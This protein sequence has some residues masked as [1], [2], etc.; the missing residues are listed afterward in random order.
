MSNAEDEKQLPMF[1]AGEMQTEDVYSDDINAESEDEVSVEEVAELT[2]YSR[3][4]TVGTIMQQIE[5]GNIDLNPKFQRRNAWNDT[6]RS[7]LIESLLLNI[8]VPEIVLA[9]DLDKK[10]S[11]IVIDGK[12]RLLAIAGY[13][14]PGKFD[15]WNRAK[16]SRLTTRKDLNG[17][18]YEELRRNAESERLL[19]NSDIRCTV[20][21]NYKSPSVLYDIFYRLNTGSTPLS[22]QELRQALHRGGFSNYLIEET[23]KSIPLHDAM[24]LSGPDR[25]LV[26]AE[27]VLRYVAISLFGGEYRGNLLQFLDASMERLNQE[28]GAREGDVRHIVAEFHETLA[29]MLS[30]LG[31]GKIGRKFTSGRWEP[32]FNRVLLEV[33]VFYLSMLRPQVASMVPEDFLSAFEAFCESDQD[34][35]DSVETTT[36]TNEKYERRY[37][38]YQSFVNGFFGVD[39]NEIPVRVAE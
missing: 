3:D 13:E 14:N 30:R 4:W 36:K 11:F 6:K 38:A 7:K 16:L 19:A 21:S 2:V 37:H 15:S 18:S 28:W 33:E 27:I 22:S 29:L 12:Q 17:L 25:R 20:I 39:I 5:Q 10:R 24:G 26:D 23:N 35:I 34:F 8:P 1:D 31:K 32:R 9:E